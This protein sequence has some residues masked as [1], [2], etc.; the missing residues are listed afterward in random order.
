MHSAFGEQPIYVS[1]NF[2]GLSKAEVWVYLLAAGAVGTM[3]KS[4]ARAYLAADR[5]DAKLL[6]TKKPIFTL[7]D[8]PASLDGYLA[9]L[10]GAVEYR[11]KE[12]GRNKRQAAVTHLG[13]GAPLSE[14][15]IAQIE[16]SLGY[17]LPDEVKCLMRQFNGL[18]CVVATLKSKKH[19]ELPD[20]P[21]PYAA[22]ADCKHPIWQDA[23]DWLCGTI[24]IPTWEDIFLRPQK[25]RMCDQSDL[26]SPGEVIKIGALKVKAGELFPRLFAFDLYHS[27]GGAA[28]YLD[29]TD[30]QAK[31]IYC[32]DA[33]ADLYSAQPIS[34]R[35][36]MESLA[37][38]I[39][40]KMGNAGQRP[41][42][43]VSKTGWPTFIRNI[44]NAPYVFVELK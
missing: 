20:Q 14:A 11:K 40:T 39:W 30:S 31:V 18:S 5:T 12:W 6:A 17:A 42:H 23:I 24:G 15:R 27:F 10:Q 32:F 38:G 37:A 4:G 16:A 25:Q 29:P 7:A 43:P 28:L 3:S 44:Q 8:L 2:E 33:F 36:Y 34:L 35:A 1:G 19:V 22:L 41:I 9:R 21:L 13:A 26:H